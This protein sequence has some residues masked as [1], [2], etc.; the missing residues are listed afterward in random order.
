MPLSAAPSPATPPTPAGA[1][2]VRVG[3]LWV[4]AL[5]FEGAL[6]RIEALV[7]AGQG[8]SVFTPNVD[9]VVTAEDDPAFRA[10][11][12]AA[13][14]SLADGQPLLWAARLLGAPLP[15]KIS[16]SD[17]LWPLVE[18]AARRRWR[19]YLL[20]GAPGVAEAA[21]E[22][23]SRE[24][25]LDV[26]GVDSPQLPLDAPAGAE[27]P[28]AERVRAAAPQ[29]LLVALGAPKQER[30]IHRNA[31]RLGPV[32]SLGIGASLDFVT[33]RIRRAPRWMSRAGLEWLHRLSQDPRRL[34]HRYLVKDPRFLGVLARTAREP[35]AARVIG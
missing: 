24:L 35:R 6:E 7:E 3:H 34:A 1:R 16:G 8:G 11:Y 31:G 27:D 30:W 4:D 15:E 20:G 9:H 10:A 26:V 17:L 25:G 23:F 33:G 18:R 5:T 2:R 29:L 22:R 28:A 21:A 19:A 12:A 13:S 14:L 32:V